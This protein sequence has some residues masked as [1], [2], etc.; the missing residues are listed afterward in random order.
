MIGYGLL[1]LGVYYTH[2]NA[3]DFSLV[4]LVRKMGLPGSILQLLGSY[5]GRFFTNLLHGLNPL[6]LGS[7]QGYKYTIVFG[8]LFSIFSFW[9]FLKSLFFRA[10]VKP[11]LVYSA[12][13][14]LINFAATPSLPH[15]IY[16]MVSSFVYLYAWCFWLLWMGSFL[17]YLNSPTESKRWFNFTITAIFIVCATGIN[18]MFLIVNIATMFL[19]IIYTKN[20]FSHLFRH[21]ILLMVIMITSM[22]FFV[23]NPGIAERFGSF[24]ETRSRF[25]FLDVLHLMWQHSSSISIKWFFQGLLVPMFL[26]WTIAFLKKHQLFF[27]VNLSYR[28]RVV[29]AIY[30]L[31]IPFLMLPAFYLPMVDT[32]L[33][34]RIFTSF[35]LVLQTSIFLIILL[36]SD[37]IVRVRLMTENSKSHLILFATT[38]AIVASFFL[39]SSNISLILDEKLDGTLDAYHQT[40][41]SR[42]EILENTKSCP[43]NTWKVAVLP[44]LV[45]YPQSIYMHPDIKPDKQEFYWNNAYEIFFDV[46]EVRL[47]GDTVNSFDYV[48][49]LLE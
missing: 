15:L 11:L 12:F 38:I 41:K 14:L 2:P 24:E 31:L 26:L 27:K 46:D 34:E 36:F 42:Y 20:N 5:D 33:P 44:K 7:L 13:F 39:Y 23:S 18:E 16:W 37:K 10:D 35:F 40:M 32:E 19:L 6:A 25:H 3:E 9:Y 48:Q 30:L 29:V 49:K 47:E 17:R 28:W 21:A 45:K 4:N 43:A 8:V 1:F 22:L